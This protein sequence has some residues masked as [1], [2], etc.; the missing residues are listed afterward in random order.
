MEIEIVVLTEAVLQAHPQVYHYTD[1]GGFQGIVDSNTLWATFYKDLNDTTEVTLLREPLCKALVQHF[2]QTIREKAKTSLKVRMAADKEGGVVA[3]A[4]SAAR[5]LV[6]A[7][8]ESAFDRQGGRNLIDP[9]IVSLCSHSDPYEQRSGLLSQ[10]RG[11]GG[12]GG[13]C[14]V[15]DTKELAELLT[16][17]QD[18]HYYAYGGVWP[19]AYAH[20]DFDLNERFPNLLS[21][22]TEV[23]AAAIDHRR[24][25]RSQD[26]PTVEI[27]SEGL[28]H[29]MTGVTLFKH[30]GFK[31]EAE[32]RI[33]AMAGNEHTVELGRKQDPNFVFAPLKEVHP[34]ARADGSQKRFIKLF[35]GLGSRL[36]IKHVIVGPSRHQQENAEWARALVGPSVPVTCSETP[37][38]PPA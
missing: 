4:T 14:L 27:P 36:P 20:D 18:R 3:S 12:N 1:R 24:T 19:V 8:Y 13:Y 10:W 33:I 25:R 28:A 11:Y 7:L 26:E 31:E 16:L 35:E 5:S 32:V 22:C 29:F 21:G 9:Y 15:F 2:V 23:F 17:E 6:A 37:Y 38:L 34:G 30:Q